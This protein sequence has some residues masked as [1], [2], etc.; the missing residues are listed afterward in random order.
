MILS[1]RFESLSAHKDA[2]QLRI[3]ICIVL[4]HWIT[5]HW[6]DFDEA[7]LSATT[8]FLK[9]QVAPVIANSANIILQLIE[10]KVRIILSFNGVYLHTIT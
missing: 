4:K 5:H 9:N 1:S 10:K 7:L 8:D 6:E 2:Q 3:R